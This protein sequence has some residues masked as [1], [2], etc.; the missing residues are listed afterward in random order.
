MSMGRSL[1]NGFKKFAEDLWGSLRHWSFVLA[2]SK[3]FTHGVV[4]GKVDLVAH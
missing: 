3:L 2:S 1:R 4:M